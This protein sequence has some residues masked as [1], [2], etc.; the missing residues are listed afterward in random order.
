MSHNLDFNEAS[1]TK[2]E[3]IKNI[4]IRT[5]RECWQQK[6]KERARCT[7]SWY[8]DKTGPENATQE[9]NEKVENNHNSN[10]SRTD[11]YFVSTFNSK[12]CCAKSTRLFCVIK[13]LSESRIEIAPHK[14]VFILY[15]YFFRFS[16]Q[17]QLSRAICL[18]RISHVIITLQKNRTIGVCR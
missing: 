7:H 11:G 4:E 3:I 9:R 15:N 14:K 2:N 12:L 10:G 1:T 13:V 8:G 17:A 16:N 6:K 18:D 5:F